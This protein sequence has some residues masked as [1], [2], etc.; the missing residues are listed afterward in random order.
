M[1]PHYQDR[2]IEKTAQKRRIEDA[3]DYP[4]PKYIK[5]ESSRRANDDSAEDQAVSPKQS[6]APSLNFAS[7]STAQPAPRM[8]QILPQ[9]I[10]DVTPNDQDEEEA[11]DEDFP[12]FEG[13][14]SIR[15]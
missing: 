2:P 6:D 15:G 7:R 12:Q 8:L 9:P 5:V 1:D 14:H 3:D 4:S 10:K 11:E 13:S